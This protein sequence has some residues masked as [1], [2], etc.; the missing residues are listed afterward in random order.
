MK[1]NKLIITILY[2]LLIPFTTTAQK[3]IVEETL[4]IKKGDRADFELKFADNITI[5][6]WDKQEVYIKAE[7]E[8]NGPHG[9]GGELNDMHKIDFREAVNGI[10]VES[11]FTEAYKKK[12]WYNGS[13]DDNCCNQ[14]KADIIYTIKVPK[15]IYLDLNSISGDIEIKGFY[16]EMKVKT[17]SGSVDLTLPKNHNADFRLKTVT[18]EVYTDM[19][20][21]FSNRKPNPI[22]GYL[23]K[24]KTGNGGALIELESVSNNLYVRK[25]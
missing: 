4:S 18:G 19:D 20:I 5:E 2:I 8:I 23:L 22:V 3:K 21:E 11:D 9:N 1:N 6:A 13:D 17:I 14:I 16:G 15:N 25:M 7:I 12:K 10:Y 24:G